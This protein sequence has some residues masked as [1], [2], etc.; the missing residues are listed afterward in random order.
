M[1]SF[2]IIYGTNM[3]AFAII[4]WFKH[5][6]NLL[7][8]Y[9]FDPYQ[10]EFCFRLIQLFESLWGTCG[11]ATNVAINMYLFVVFISI[12]F[13]YSLLSERASQIGHQ[14]AEQPKPNQ[15]QIYQDMIEL[16]NVHL[17]INE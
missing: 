13:Y 5:A 12:N 1:N 2:G 15:I 6:L 10:N 14:I 7:L 3:A 11:G 4:P 17:K 16:I 8:W 9:P